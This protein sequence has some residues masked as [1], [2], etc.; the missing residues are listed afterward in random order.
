MDRVVFYIHGEEHTWGADPVL[1]WYRYTICD[2]D[3]TLGQRLVSHEMFFDVQSCKK[4]GKFTVITRV[5]VGQVVM[6]LTY[7][8]PQPDPGY[9]DNPGYCGSG[10]DESDIWSTT[11]WPGLPW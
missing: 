11:A 4:V 10:G 5:T 6:G 9:R 1:L 7:D 8:L 2:A 3:R